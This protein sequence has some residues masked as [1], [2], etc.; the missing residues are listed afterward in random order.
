MDQACFLY[1]WFKE[2]V[3][4]WLGISRGPAKTGVKSAI[5]ETA[6]G[7][8]WASRSVPRA[9]SKRPGSDENFLHTSRLTR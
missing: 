5:L 1:R 6:S 3:S 4:H 7:R 2:A 8:T 9:L